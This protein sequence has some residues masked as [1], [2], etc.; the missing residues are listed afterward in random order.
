MYQNL[1]ISENN[2]EQVN[3]LMGDELYVIDEIQWF[4]EIKSEGGNKFRFLNIVD[5]G[6]EHII[7]ETERDFFF[8]II[9]SIKN[10]KFSM[11]ADGFS[12]VNI[13]DYKGVKWSNLEQL[14]S[15]VYCIFWG[16]NPEK[17]GIHCKL[18]GGALQ[19]NC[20]ILY[21]D[22][23]KDISENQDKKKQLWSL[24]K[25]MFQIQ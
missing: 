11:D 10:D 1:I 23:I 17:V 18:W 7:P 20:R 19:G 3:M 21:V 2:P 16:A 8:R 12:I 25:R 15:P 22:S 9:T 13:S 4:E 24:V 6:N 5:H 14:F